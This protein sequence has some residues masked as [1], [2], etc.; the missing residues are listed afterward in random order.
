MPRSKQPATKTRSS[1]ENTID[2]FKSVDA[3]VAS[4]DAWD[5]KPDLLVDAVLGLL[6]AG[7]GIMFGRAWDGE[8]LVIT[9]YDGDSKTRKYISDSIEF[10][11]AL[12]MVCQRLKAQEEREKVVE[13]RANAR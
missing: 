9:V 8:Q 11:D 3:D 13:M 4:V 5:I 6:S 2:W 10:D 1:S 7:K 12:A